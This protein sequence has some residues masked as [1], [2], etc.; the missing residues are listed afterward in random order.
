MLKRIV[1]SILFVF[2]LVVSINAGSWATIT[3][4]SVDVDDENKLY[5]YTSGTNYVFVASDYYTSGTVEPGS[6]VENRML[7]TILQV[8]AIGGTLR[9]WD[10]GTTYGSFHK[11]NATRIKF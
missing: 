11:I 1:Q 8:K 7:S 9:V 3:V 2:A 4:D 5:I 6:V 10:L